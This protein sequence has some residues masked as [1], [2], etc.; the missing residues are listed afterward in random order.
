MGKVVPL[1]CKNPDNNTWQAAKKSSAVK[2]GDAI[3]GWVGFGDVADFIKFQVAGDG[4][5]KL[6]LDQA[7]AKALSGKE[8]KLSCLDASGKAV[9]MGSLDS[10]TLV[11]KK[12]VLA[13]EYYL[14]VT[15]TNVK[16]FDTSYSITTSVAK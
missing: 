3:T 4:Q 10:D 5:I 7:T 13:G 16:K 9:A 2:S 11:S 14:G 15:C 1:H 6:D 12:P 8:I